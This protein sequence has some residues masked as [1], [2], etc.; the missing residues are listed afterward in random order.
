LVGEGKLIFC[1]QLACARLAFA[2]AKRRHREARANREQEASFSLPRPRNR[3]EDA[4]SRVAPEAAPNVRLRL[5][6]SLSERS[7]NSLVL[8][9]S[10]GSAQRNGSDASRTRLPN[11]GRNQFFFGCLS[12]PYVEPYRPDST[13]G[14]GVFTPI[15]SRDGLSGSRGCD[16]RAYGARS[17]PSRSQNGGHMAEFESRRGIGVRHRQPTGRC[18]PYKDH[19]EPPSRSG[20]AGKTPFDESCGVLPAGA[21]ATADAGI[22]SD[23]RSS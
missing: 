21:W 20:R 4:R 3:G 19:S 5:E 7:L 14:N 1:E 17:R 12:S 10:I 15:R 23:M 18:K 6:R 2:Q 22:V 9:S 8:D 16:A 13:D 11:L